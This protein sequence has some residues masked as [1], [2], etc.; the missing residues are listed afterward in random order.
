MLSRCA[1][2]APNTWLSSATRLLSAMPAAYFIWAREKPFALRAPALRIGRSS[3]NSVIESTPTINAAI[4]LSRNAEIISTRNCK[5]EEISEVV[6][7]APPTACI[8]WLVIISC[9]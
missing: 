2:P 9:S 4:G 3:A 6:L 7:T 5:L 1:V 8:T